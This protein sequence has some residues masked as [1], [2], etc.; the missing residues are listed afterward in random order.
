MPMITVNIGKAKTRLSR[1]LRELG[2][3]RRVVITWYGRPTARRVP[4]EPQAP[5]RKPGC[6]KGRIQIAAD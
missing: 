6:L 3:G 5:S 2:A 1:L 4:M